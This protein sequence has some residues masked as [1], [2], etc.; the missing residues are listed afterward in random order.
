MRHY[1]FNRLRQK[2]VVQRVSS[3]STETST[4]NVINMTLIA[5]LIMDSD[6][7]QEPLG[8]CT[9]LIISQ[10]TITGGT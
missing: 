10:S 2:R 6:N 7:N 5:I 4:I 3:T 8:D 9:K 1:S